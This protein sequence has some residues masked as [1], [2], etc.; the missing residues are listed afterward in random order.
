MRECRSLFEH[1]KTGAV[2]HLRLCLQGA[3][4]RARGE[5][6]AVAFS[7]S[8]VYLSVLIIY[9]DVRDRFG[10]SSGLSSGSLPRFVTRTW[11][12]RSNVAYMRCRA[13]G[14]ERVWDTYCVRSS[15][16]HGRCSME[17]KDRAG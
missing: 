5:K 7:D 15:S 13:S 3:E 9:A 4:F 11:T 16:L 6:N 17:P 2:E 10:M 14:M 12:W 8:F 1:I